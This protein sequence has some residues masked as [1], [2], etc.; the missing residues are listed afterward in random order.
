L[1]PGMKPDFGTIKPI[2][3]TMALD[4]CAKHCEHPG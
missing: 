3:L 2:A 4:A 1:E